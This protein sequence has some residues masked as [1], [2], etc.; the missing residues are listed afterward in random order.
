MIVDRNISSYV[1]SSEASIRDALGRID[2]NRR[3]IVFG[4][5]RDGVLDGILTDGDFRRWLLKEP[6]PDFSRPVGGILNTQFRRA[7]LGDS[8]EQMRSILSGKTQ[9]IPMTDDRGR[10][11]AVARE[12]RKED[13]IQ[14]GDFLIENGSPTF[15]I[16]EIGINH[17]GSVELAKRLIDAAKEAGADCAKF[18]MRDLA[19]L[20]RNQL[21]DA[22]NEDLG[23]QYTMNLLSKFELPPEEMKLLF[24]YC[25]ARGLLPLCTPW[26]IPSLNFLEA[27]G[28]Q[29]YKIASADLTNHELIGAVARTNKTILCSTGMSMESEIV[30]T[31]SLLN[32]LGS[33]YVLLHCNSTYPAPFKDVN[34]SYMARLKEIGGCHVGYSGHERGVDVCVAAVALGARVIEK[35]ITLDRSMEG[36]DHKVSL[37]PDEFRRMVLAIRDVEQAIGSSTVRSLS[38]GEVMNRVT[39]AKSLVA[40]RDVAVGEVITEDMIATKSPGRGLQ[41]NRKMELIGRRIGR[42]MRKGD[43]FFPSDLDVVATSARQYSFKRKW[44]LPVRYHDFGLLLQKSNPDFLEFHLSFKDMD[45]DVRR[46]IDGEFDLGLVVHSPDTFAGDHLLNLASEDKIHR[47]RSVAELQRVIDLTREMKRFFRRADRP[48]IVASLGGA[49]SDRLLVPSERARLY[50]IMAESLQKL[51]T[52]GVE[53][54]G[55]TLPPFPWYFGGQLYLNLFVEAADT[56]EFCRSQNLRLCLDICHSKLACNHYKV[57]F[58][59]F[60]R[61]VG[62]FVAHLHISDALGVDGEGVQIGE[63]DIDFTGLGEDLCE[64]APDASFIPEIWQGHKNEGEGF[65]KALERLEGHL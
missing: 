3:R 51:D 17:N 46:F 24:E 25:S 13:A 62:P 50:E 22:Y 14:I 64:V 34:L 65:W 57:S 41:P 49:T 33:Q 21:S 63:G 42:C 32:R 39:L 53:I 12:R 54:I 58:K 28:M 61:T 40:A 20:Y 1:I 29:G 38:P 27:I 44:G 55:Q 48:M 23:T 31:V 11:V 15:I 2:Q 52:D 5:D 8:V 47:K 43:F 60:I 35:H 4:V 45:E 56:A 6:S 26:D 18:Q 30:E 19:S 16:A 37:L 10:M 7:H 36:N 9:Y 59:E